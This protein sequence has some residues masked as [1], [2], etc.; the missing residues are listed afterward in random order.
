MSYTLEWTAPHRAIGHLA[1]PRDP[2]PAGGWR[3]ECWRDTT[4]PEDAWH[5]R[6]GC[7]TEALRDWLRAWP[8][9]TVESCTRTQ[10]DAAQVGAA[11]RELLDDLAGTCG[12]VGLDEHPVP[13]P[14]SWP[15]AEPHRPR[16]S[17][18]AATADANRAR[19]AFEGL[20][21]TVDR[22]RTACRQG[23]EL[24]AAQRGRLR[25][26]L[27]ELRELVHGVRRDLAALE[28]KPLRDPTACA[29]C[30]G[31]GCPCCTSTPQARVRELR[32]ELLRLAE[33][34]ELAGR[35]SGGM[36]CTVAADAVL[37]GL[38]HLADTYTPPRR[39]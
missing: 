29:A 34:A 1:D 38:R 6:V 19:T 21:A 2:A 12:G 4:A 24:A 13:P 14:P 33:L 28:G 35:N 22:D 10:P 9:Y 5:L 16:P 3:V 15:A 11:L 26:D 17:L 27:C 23:L 30:D 37:A 7:R 20:A 36:A 18:Q 32:P 31:E 8:R 39:A 25:S